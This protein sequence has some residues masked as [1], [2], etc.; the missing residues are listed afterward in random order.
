MSRA[1]RT[2]PRRIPRQSRSRATV[3]AI[4]EAAA[5]VLETDG[6]Q[7][8]NVNRVAALAGVSIGSLYQYFP[9]KEALAAGVAKQLSIRMLDTFGRDLLDLA[10]LPPREAIVEVVGRAIQAFRVA[11]RL[12][13]VLHDEVL[14]AGA[15][16]QTTEFDST[17]RVAFVGYLELHRS[18]MRPQ[19]LD[20]AVR[21]VMTAVEG[22]AETWAGDP[23][24]DADTLARETAELVTRY[25]LRD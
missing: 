18:A 24:L 17:L 5:R 23:A 20:M 22:I 14:A 16:F 3:D 19:D 4:L 12:R 15:A 7:Q 11:P 6:Y 13:R 2:Q 10:S 21:V 1:P 9:T 25:L 8:A